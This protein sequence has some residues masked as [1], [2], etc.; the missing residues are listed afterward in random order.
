MNWL[1]VVEILAEN[2]DFGDGKPKEGENNN[3]YVGQ[4]KVEDTSAGFE[5][6]DDDELLF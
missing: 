4:Q 2:V 5:E 1:N 6:V 3:Q